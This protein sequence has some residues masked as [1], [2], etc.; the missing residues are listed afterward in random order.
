VKLASIGRSKVG[1]LLGVRF[2]KLG[3]TKS[4]RVINKEIIKFRNI[5]KKII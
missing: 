1:V 2:A 3:L 5:A 4:N